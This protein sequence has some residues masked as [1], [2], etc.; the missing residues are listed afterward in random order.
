MP[1]KRS[2]AGVLSITQPPRCG[3]VPRRLF[4]FTE[5]QPAPLAPSRPRGPRNMRATGWARPVSVAQQTKLC[6]DR[7]EDM[8]ASTVALALAFALAASGFGAAMAQDALQV[9]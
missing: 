6:R 4:G 2:A 1:T 5:N 7:R 8:K 3:L 9:I